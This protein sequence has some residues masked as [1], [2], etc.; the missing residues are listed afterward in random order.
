MLAKLQIDNQNG[1]SAKNQVW[2]RI[3]DQTK[4][5]CG[6]SVLPQSWYRVGMASWRQVKLE[7]HQLL[8]EEL[9]ESTGKDI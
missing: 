5:E 7:V 4:I 8:Q 2:A 3:T 6:V 1:E 9:E